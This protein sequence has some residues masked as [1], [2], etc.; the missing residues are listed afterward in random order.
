MNRLYIISRS[1]V[2]GM[3]HA[4]MDLHLPSAQV[5][6]IK[7]VRDT[8][9]A[10]AECIF[11]MGDQ[12]PDNAVEL[13]TALSN[14][15]GLGF[16]S[17]AE[18]Q[19]TMQQLVDRLRYES[20]MRRSSKSESTTKYG[21]DNLKRDFES[22]GYTEERGFKYQFTRDSQCKYF[23]FI[24]ES[25]RM[26]VIFNV[27]SGYMETLRLKETFHNPIQINDPNGLMKSG[28]TFDYNKFTAKFG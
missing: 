6:V 3:A 18:L 14:S 22:A 7:N 20:E 2:E 13:K 5:K 4:S 8:K 11:V 1:E 9:M 15:G 10:P 17:I 12:L 25:P 27:F 28:N 24:P 23:Y 21:A 16:K 19:N 26:Q